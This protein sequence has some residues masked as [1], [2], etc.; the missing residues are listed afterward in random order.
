MRRV[1]TAIAAIA[2]LVGVAAAPASAQEEMKAGQAKARDLGREYT[3]QFYASKLEPLHAKFTKDMADAMS[4][5]RFTQVRQ[6]L[7]EQLGAE[8]EVL[9]ETVE[10]KD[11]YLVYLRRAKFAKFP[12][13]IVVQWALKEGG[14]IAGVF[15]TPEQ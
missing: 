7:D 12:G 6:Q 1:M 2:L 11:G 13:V 8:T 15:L 14:E 10:S 3:E 9:G 5:E 4:L